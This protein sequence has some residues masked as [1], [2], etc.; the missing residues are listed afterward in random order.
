MDAG[1]DAQREELGTIE[2]DLRD[3]EDD[4][5]EGRI[6][7]VSEALSLPGAHKGKRRVRMASGRICI[8]KPEGG[9]EDWE[10]AAGCEAAA[11]VVARRLGLEQLVPVTIA[12]V[13]KLPEGDDQLAALQLWR[14]SQEEDQPPD[15]F[16]DDEIT[17]AALFDYLTEQGDRDNHNW[18]TWRD[19]ADRPHLRLADN[20]CAFGG[21]GWPLRST[22]YELRRG[23]RLDGPTLAVLQKLRDPQFAQELEPLL[24]RALIRALLERVE[25]LIDQRRLP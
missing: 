22:F 13:I 9:V 25:R 8:A 18:L 11:W 4:L 20:G 16:P 15:A 19:E 6:D 5:R 21:R 2:G 24:P 17:S 10:H 7:H 14:E 1:Q 23:R 3:V 12:R